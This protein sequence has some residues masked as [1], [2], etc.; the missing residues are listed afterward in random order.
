MIVYKATNKI[1]GKVYIGYTSKS[2]SERMYAH[3]RKANNS[4]EKSFNQAFKLALRKYGVDNFLW[5]ELITCDTKDEACQLEV[6]MIKKHNCITPNGYN[7]TFG[8]EG[9]TPN[10]EVK[11]KI[12]ET[13]IKF[14]S[15]NPRYFVDRYMS[16]TT[17]EERSEKGKRGYRTRLQNGRQ[18]K[19]GH[20]Q[21][22]SAK[23][24]MSESKAI[25]Y[26][27]SWY[28]ILTKEIVVASP[29]QMQNLTGI[30]VGT[31]TH[32]KHGRQAINKSGWI[33]AGDSSSCYVDSEMIFS[34]FTNR[35]KFGI[36]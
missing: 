24:K 6:D 30:S 23:I 10:E 13:L 20:V 14:N 5:E 29:K 9:G 27:S 12:S 16:R 31:F 34:K 7:M 2:L 35:F 22:E 1:N 18:P 11:K 26:A 25:L 36:K 28:N 3:N 33:F 15:E 17:P 21:T 8:G 32:L 4:K 19:P